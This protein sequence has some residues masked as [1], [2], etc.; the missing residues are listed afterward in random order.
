LDCGALHSPTCYLN[1][2]EQC[3]GKTLM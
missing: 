1:V 2:L 3:M